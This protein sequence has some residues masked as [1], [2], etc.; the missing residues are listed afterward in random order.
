MR[1]LSLLFSPH[2]SDHAKGDKGIFG[3]KNDVNVTGKTKVFPTVAFILLF[4]KLLWLKF[5]I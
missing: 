5:K 1:P 4:K 2:L 3:E